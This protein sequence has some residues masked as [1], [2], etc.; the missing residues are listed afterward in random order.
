MKQWHRDVQRPFI[1]NAPATT[2]ARAD[3]GW[4]WPRTFPWIK[5]AISLAG[6]QNFSFAFVARNGNGAP[7]TVAIA[8]GIQPFQCLQFKDGRRPL[9]GF[10]WYVTGIPSAAAT[11]LGLAG[12]KITAQALATCKDICKAV[13]PSSEIVLHADPKGPS[14][15]QFYVQKCMMQQIP[16]DVVV[17]APLKRT[18]DGRYF[19]SGQP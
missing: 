9:D 8:L 13:V 19:Y 7:V 12:L 4:N 15:L 16:N 11:H 5:R 3:V 10:V 1:D 2:P 6:E 17:C 18:N 14:L